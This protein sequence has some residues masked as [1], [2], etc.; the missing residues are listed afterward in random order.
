[1][2]KEQI[3]KGLYEAYE[4]AGHNAYFGNGFEAGIEFAESQAPNKGM[5]S[6]EEMRDMA[7]NGTRYEGKEL[8]SYH[9]GLK[10][11]RSKLSPQETS[12]NW[13]KEKDCA[14][15]IHELRVRDQDDKF[16]PICG[17]NLQPKDIQK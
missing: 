13:V 9:Q 8:V 14:T 12:D 2:K 7:Y 15:E 3:R 1:M 4:K 16:C 6:D 5:I 10:D 11:M 17:K